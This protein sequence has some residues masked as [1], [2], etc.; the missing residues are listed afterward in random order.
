MKNIKP[1][2]V[3]IIMDGNGR[4]ASNRKKSRR[5][6]HKKGATT[7]KNIVKIVIFIKG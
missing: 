5:Y 4:W 3:A 6:G 7:A 2:H 1:D